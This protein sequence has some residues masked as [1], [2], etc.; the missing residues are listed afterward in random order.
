MT[1]AG[2]PRF[3]IELGCNWEEE[4]GAGVRFVGLKIVEAGY[5]A[6]AFSFPD[7]DAP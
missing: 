3:G 6:D 7:D 1:I 5:A 4:H 2:E